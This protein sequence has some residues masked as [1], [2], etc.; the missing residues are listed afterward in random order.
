[1]SVQKKAEW[2]P[3]CCRRGNSTDQKEE[4]QAGLEELKVRGGNLEGISI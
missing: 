1:M 2:S 3:S 4:R